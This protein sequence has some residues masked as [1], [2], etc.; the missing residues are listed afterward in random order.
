MNDSYI[1]LSMRSLAVFYKHGFET[2]SPLEEYIR[3]ILHQLDNI[4]KCLPKLPPGRTSNPDA[5]CRLALS[6]CSNATPSSP[7]LQRLVDCKASAHHKP[8]KKSPKKKTRCDNRV[9]SCI[10][11]MIR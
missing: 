6:Y 5:V 10:P 4:I 8:D 3:L 11:S 1:W 7:N 9:V 2:F